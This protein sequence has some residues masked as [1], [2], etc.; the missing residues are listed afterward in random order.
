[1]G[2]CKSA[3][4]AFVDSLLPGTIVQSQ[5]FP[6]SQRM[7]SVMKCQRCKKR[8]ATART[9]GLIMHLRLPYWTI[10]PK[11]NDRKCICCSS[12]T[13]EYTICYGAMHICNHRI[14]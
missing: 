14:P 1:V 6:I 3:F 9:I 7:R 8:V 4:R 12:C 5:Y 2:G 11:M 10:E 13:L